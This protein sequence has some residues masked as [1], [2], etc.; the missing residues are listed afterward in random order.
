MQY[1]IELGKQLVNSLKY[2]EKRTNMKVKTSFLNLFVFDDIYT[3]DSIPEVLIFLAGAPKGLYDAKT[4]DK[5]KEIKKLLNKMEYDHDYM[6]KKDM[7]NKTLT[8]IDP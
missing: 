6:L 3:L 5:E 2:I 7:K 4:D 8:I 1:I